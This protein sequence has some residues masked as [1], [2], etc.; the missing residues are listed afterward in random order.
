MRIQN[1]EFRSQKISKYLVFF[2]SVFWIL[3]SK[4]NA[5]RKFTYCDVIPV[6][7]G[8]QYAIMRENS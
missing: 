7:A 3:T 1:P 6:K 4:P 8:I 2:H 5:F